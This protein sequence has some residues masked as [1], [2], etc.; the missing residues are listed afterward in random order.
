MNIGGFQKLTLTDFPGRV[1]AMI[2]TRGCN[3]ACPYCHN[4]ELLDGKGGACS[5]GVILDYLRQ[6]GQFLDGVVITGGEPTLQPDLFGFISRLKSMDLLVKLDTN[7]SNPHVL[8]GLLDQGLIDYVAMDIKAGWRNYGLVTGR[9]GAEA[10]CRKTMEIIR[11][12]GVEYEFRTTVYPAVNDAAD[13]A[14]IRSTILPG[15]RYNLQEMRTGTCLDD[16][17]NRKARETVEIDVSA[18][19]AW[20]ARET[21]ELKIAG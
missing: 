15:E 2:F 13:L 4:P 9:P 1:A 7:G 18:L 11:Q 10:S 14:A 5:P 20:K 3:F 16:R 8:R 6:R 21:V 17:L 12:S 19:S